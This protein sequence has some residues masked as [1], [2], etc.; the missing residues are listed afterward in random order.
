VHVGNAR[1]RASYGLDL[2]HP[3]VGHMVVEVMRR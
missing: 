3:D 1:L 2:H